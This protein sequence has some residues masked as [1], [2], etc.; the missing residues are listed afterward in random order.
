MEEFV[1]ELVISKQKNN[2]VA[3]VR[4][5]DGRVV[6]FDPSKIANA[7]KKAF[8]ATGESSPLYDSKVQ[9]MDG[10][11]NFLKAWECTAMVVSKLDKKIVEIEHIQ[12]VVED[13]LMNLGYRKTA[14]AYILYRAK[15]AEIRN[16]Q[17]VLNESLSI[18]EGYLDLKDWRVNENS[19][20]SYSLQGLNAHVSS[21]I[22]AN[23]WLTK[24]Y[25]PDI[26]EAHKNGFFHIH[27][28][29]S[30][31]AYCVGWDLE[32]LL[33]NGFSGVVG[34]VESKPAKHFRTALGQIVNFFYTLQ[35]EAAGAQAF[36]NF[37]TLLAPF[38][39]YDGLT[40]EEVK[41]A[42][43][44]FVFNLNVPTRTGFQTPFTNITFDLKC[45]PYFENHGVII[46]GEIQNETYKEF[47][48]EMQWIN[49][50]FAEVMLEGDA[51]GRPFTFPI[52][53]YNISKNFDF[54]NPD[55]LPIWEMTA[56]YGTPYFSNFVN[57]DMKEE[58]A[59]S[60]CLHPNEKIIIKINGKIKR[61]T[62]G[63]LLEIY[64]TK[65]DKEGWAENKEDIQALS[66][67]PVSYKVE[68]KNIKRFFKTYD[69]CL[70]TIET[71][72]GKKMRLS[73]DHP[74]A[75]YTK[76]GITYKKAI[77]LSNND[78][79]LVLRN[80]ENVLNNDTVFLGKYEIDKE[81]AF[82]L[83]FFIA[84]G[85]YLYDTREQ[86]SSSGKEKGIQFSFNNEDEELI[87][88]VRAIISKKFNY[89]LKFKK[90]PRFDHSLYAYF[91]NAEI[92]RDFAEAGFNKYG[93]IPEIIFNSRK[94]IIIS[95]L[96]GFF[97][98]D[99]YKKG[100]E[101]HI[102]DEM[103]ANDIVLLF[104][105]AGIPVTIKYREN[106][107]VIRIQHTHGRG[108]QSGNVVVD[109]NRIPQFIVET[110]ADKPFYD[111]DAL[112]SKNSLDK[113][114]AHTEESSKILSDNIALVKIKSIKIE[115][116]PYKQDFYDIEL[117]ENHYFVHSLGNITHNCCRL[118]LDNREVRNQLNKHSK[119]E[120][121][122]TPRRGGIFAANP[123][124]GSIGVVTINLPRIAYLSKTE[125]EFFEKLREIMILAKN[126]LEMKRKV[127][128][129]LTERG[130]YPYTKVYLNDIKLRSGNYWTNHFSTIGL[131]GMNEA[132]M[133]LLKIPYHLEEG[134][135]FAEKVLDFMLE[136]LEEFK[137]TTGHLYNLEASPAE[138]ASYRLAKT[139][140]K[141][142]KDIITS[143]TDEV[144][145]YTNSVHLPVNYSDDIYEVLDFQ[146]SLQSRFTGGTVIHIFLGEKINTPKTV[147]KLVYKIAS[148]YRLPYFSITPTF[149]IC[150]VHGYIAGEHRYCPLPH[151]EEELKRYGIIANKHTKT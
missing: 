24:I 140:K 54:E 111:K 118:R 78:I 90:D 139:D 141:D 123:M 101:I 14:K 132:V 84:D 13:T 52:P 114:N 109:N 77:E 18:I 51:K 127:I 48:K 3:F 144:P 33:I 126:S 67:N 143:G 39:R 23:Y 102:N 47:T 108:N 146:D 37:D 81:L 7:I 20:M 76:E 11:G 21:T 124:T 66:F 10:Q 41:Q 45:P 138:G 5:R 149:S 117:E 70:I 50:A 79:L 145:Y 85:N 15:R 59:R 99:G 27:D 87:E 1:K 112:V 104:S 100:N 151:N 28:L 56:K 57:S 68:W 12:D 29:G 60:M 58:D 55:F 89:E 119:K 53:T 105:L 88:K 17:R 16:I 32:M 35:G 72:D 142:F 38:I 61:T 75:I 121:G 106:S 26:G 110:G 31:S 8:D 130:L 116:L 63:E 134:K 115:N 131:I 94:E 43:Q 135:S 97:A 92:A 133:N 69:N 95:F 122:Q 4:K 30:L 71:Y 125:N 98:G 148:N 83:G 19:N 103:L 40:Y 73:K 44:E 147:G 2:Q 128:E 82:L 64:V 120:D 91:Y 80:G 129:E 65:Y 93:G 36:A 74:V 22:V 46:G 25:T 137:E 9:Q 107:Q 96:E 113:R 86:Y 34:K 136:V 42:M 6:E 62:I 49:R 150:P